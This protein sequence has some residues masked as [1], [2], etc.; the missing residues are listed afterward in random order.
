MT[1]HCAQPR[2]ESRPK[3]VGVAA[4][5]FVAAC[6]TFPGLPSAGHPA[7]ALSE[8]VLDCD[9]DFN[10][11]SD[12]RLEVDNGLSAIVEVD[13]GA[14]CHN[15]ASSDIDPGYCDAI[16]VSEGTY[17]IEIRRM[18]EDG[19]WY[20][21]VEAVVSISSGQTVRINLTESLLSCLEPGPPTMSGPGV[22][23]SGETYT[24]SWSLAS[25]NAAVYEL[26]ESTDPSFAGATQL[27]LGA[28]SASFTHTVTTPRTFYYRVRATVRCASSGTTYRSAWSESLNVHVIPP[29]ARPDPPVLS[30]PSQ[31]PGGEGYT[32]NWT[33]TSGDDTYEWE[34]STDPGF[35]EVTRGTVQQAS[36]AFSHVVSTTTTFYC[37]V[38]AFESCGGETLYSDW[39][40]A[41]AVEVVAV[42]YE[43]MVAGVAALPGAGSTEWRT[44]L[45]VHNLTSETASL[46]LTYRHGAGGVDQ[47]WALAG[48]A[49]VGWD[50]VVTSLFGVSGQSAGAVAV[51][52][53][54]PLLVQA[55]T[56][57]DAPTGT[58]GQYLPGVS[59]PDYLEAT[60]QGVLG[61]LRGAP[62]FRT[63]VGFVNPGSSP[64]DA[65]IT[66]F[67]EA[68]EQLGDPVTASVPAGGWKQVNDVFEQANATSPNLGYAI[69]EPTTP[70]GRVWAYASVVDGSSGDPTTV[71]VAVIAPS[72]SRFSSAATTVGA[73]GIAPVAR[74]LQN[75]DAGDASAEPGVGNTKRGDGLFR[76]A[77]GFLPSASLSGE[78]T[79]MVA[80]IAATPGTAGT[81]WRSY[82]SVCNLT[83]ELAGITLVYRD[84]S[85]SVTRSWELD[86]GAIVG[87]DDVVSELFGVASPSAGAVR[88]LSDQPVLVQARTYND[89]AGGTFGQY[90]PGVSDP[91]YLVAGNKGVLGQIRGAPS[92][93]TNVGFVNPGSSACE[94]LIT[95]FSKT[96]E[97]LGSP[98]T[99]TVPAEG[100]KQVNDV[101]ARAQAGSVDL[102][103]ATVEPTTQ[104]G[105]VWAYASVVDASSGDPTTIPAVAADTGSQ[106]GPDEIT[107]LLPGDVPL[108]LVRIPAG[109][110]MMGSPADEPGRWDRE[111][112]HQVTLTHEYYLGKY[113]VTQ[114]QWQAVMGTNPSYFQ[115]CGGSCPVEEVSWNDI[116]G[117]GG[118][119]EQLNQYLGTDS[120][121]LPTEAE[122]E[123]AAR[124]GSEAP[125]SFGDDMSCSL[126]TCSACALFAL[127]MWWC[128]N[129]AGTTHPSG[130]KDPNAYGLY[131]MYGNVFE[132]VQDRFQYHLGT[133][134]VTDPTGPLTGSSRVFRGGSWNFYA[135]SCRSAT[136]Y[137]N[138]PDYRHYYPGF[139]LARS[140]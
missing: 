12:A 91:E 67:S 82:L 123:R 74:P 125:F 94:V 126:D 23:D 132:W 96:G 97:Q 60:E 101:F 25:S 84:D 30:G 51:T 53:N 77:K 46:T 100:Y 83:L 62:S 9:L 122:W 56:Y 124:A 103:F 58:F 81:A 75:V 79:Y 71:P 130:S 70:G 139:R 113:E 15:A 5:V 105:R 38:R 45:S 18:P 39:S 129:A 66:L 57:N 110:F 80:G 137:Y 16:T 64:C 63:N 22:V 136:R 140:G 115:S 98:L 27:S 102:G 6:L 50:D 49:T 41:H 117:P 61:Q 135:R 33:T 54:R 90:L 95:L 121:R 20:D 4:L 11:G 73:F 10:C 44:Y 55:R 116:A 8:H 133:S 119:V 76:H 128:G 120:F 36:A 89:A 65:R 32:I 85:G 131:D 21:P 87:W 114:A 1:D 52:S 26:Q 127:Q 47:D 111:D 3:A 28:N 2:E 68:G 43:S 99:T 37:R 40:D 112:L 104:G 118:F 106:Q 107:V 78:H 109:T 7:S 93:R 29:C 35:A 138:A 31:V 69:V 48:G 88:V 34:E 42:S 14:A 92:F 108:T 59:D 24:V 72:T 134:P 13:W 19:P 86:G 17:S